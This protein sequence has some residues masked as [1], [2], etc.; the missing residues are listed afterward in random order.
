MEGRRLNQTT[1]SSSAAAAALSSPSSHLQMNPG[2]VLL[3]DGSG[4]GET[5]SLSFF[6]TLAVA[7][8]DD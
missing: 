7:A 8:A 1:T 6:S 2:H 4:K 5:L 3:F